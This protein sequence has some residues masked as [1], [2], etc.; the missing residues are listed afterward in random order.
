LHQTRPACARLALALV[1]AISALGACTTSALGAPIKYVALGDSYS[2][3]E[4]LGPYYPDSDAPGNTCHRSEAGWP[5]LLG[6]AFGYRTYTFACS[7]ATTDNV[8]GTGRYG[9]LDHGAQVLRPDLVDANL[10]TISIG[11]NDVNFAGVL[12]HCF[13]VSCDKD[14]TPAK[15]EKAITRRLPARLDAAFAAIRAHAPK[16]ATVVVVGYPAVFPTSYFRQKFCFHSSVY[17]AGEDTFLNRDARSL[18]GVEGDAARRA[19]FFY[20]SP[21]RL[22]RGH[23]YCDKHGGQD[24]LPGAGPLGPLPGGAWINGT[25]AGGPGG[26]GAFHPRHAGARALAELVASGLST[27]AGPRTPSTGLP[28]NPAPVP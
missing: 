19:G 26:P 28:V 11:G 14:G 27:Y 18:D 25:V 9:G 1:V 2:S 24:A 15:T 7:G 20:V 16:S 23:A 3:G 13:Y 10:V 21:L 4:G 6:N 5:L 8:I 12:K 22:F 17:S